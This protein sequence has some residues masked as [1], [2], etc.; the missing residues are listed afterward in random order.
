M[1]YSQRKNNEYEKD[2]SREKQ[3][4]KSKTRKSFKEKNRKDTKKK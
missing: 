4:R 3:L 2:I 1:D